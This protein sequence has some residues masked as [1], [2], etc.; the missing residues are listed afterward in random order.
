MDIFWN[1]PFD[2]GVSM[3]MAIINES[4]GK[5]GTENWIQF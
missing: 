5:T 2:E 3:H 1:H 4:I